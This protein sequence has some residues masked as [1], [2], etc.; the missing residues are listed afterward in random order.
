MSDHAWVLEN[1]ASYVAGGL[2][3]EERDQIEEHAAECAGCARAVAEAR[4]VQRRLATLF[5]E[6]RPHPALEDWSIQAL[7]KETQLPG[8]R[9]FPPWAKGLLAAAAAVVLTVVGAYA[10]TLIDEDQ[11]G[12]QR[13]LVQYK[14]GSSREPDWSA[15]GIIDDSKQSQYLFLPGQ[16]RR[17][18]H[19]MASALRKE[20]ETKLKDRQKEANDPLTIT[21]IDPAAIKLDAE[22]AYNVE[23][24][25]D[26]SVPGV[27]NPDETVARQQQIPPA[28][29]EE[30]EGGWRYRDKGNNGD[31]R[32]GYFQPSVAFTNCCSAA[33]VTATGKDVVGGG[34]KKA[35]PR[36]EQAGDK[37]GDNE[38]L[39]GKPGDGQQP[40]K[41]EPPA[42]VARKIIRSGEL[43]FEVDSFNAAAAVISR[44]VLA[45]KGGFV[46]SERSTK[47]PNG[48]MRGV[49]IVRLPPEQLD[50]IVLDL[51][52]ELSKTGELRGQRIGSEDVSKV[53]TDLDSELR[54][55][56]T[57]E[58]RLLKIIRDGKGQIKEL[59]QAE[60][61]LGEWR[62]KIERL[63]GELR[64]LANQVSLSTLTVKLAE[65]DIRTAAAVA[66][67][68]RVQT[69]IEVED[70]E[71]ARAAALKAVE[72]AKGRVTKSEL[73]QHAAGQFSAALHFEVEPES[74]GTVRDR[75]RQLGTMVRLEI[76]RVQYAE[77][78]GPAPKDG[79]V[80]RGRT[81]FF[82]SLYNLAN[83]SPR[84]TVTLT[85]AAADVA[86]AFRTLREALAKARGR[87]VNAQLNEK[88]RKNVTAQLDFD[89]LRPEEGAVT[90][91]LTG[92][93]EVVSRH[94][95]RLPEG[96]NVTDAK[97]LFKVGLVQA[98][99][100]PARETVK[101]KVAAADVPAGE[102]RLREALTKARGRLVSRQL[103]EQDRKNVTALLDFDV[104]RS[105]ESVVQAALKELGEVLSRHV[106]RQPE[107]EAV[108]DAK[109]LYKVE[110][111]QA[112]VQ[113]ARET[114][115]LAVEVADV[116]AALAV[117]DARVKEAG[118]R[119]EQPT[120]TQEPNGQV[121]ATVTVK[122]P[123][124]A[125]TGLVEKLKA[126]GQVRVWRQARNPK[127]PEGKLAH[128]R[129]DVTLSN[130][131][132]LVPRDEG[133][134]SQVRS[135][136]SLS[137]HGLL[138]SARWLVVGVLFVL[139]WLLLVAAVVWL[140]RRLWRGG[141][142]PA[143]AASAAGT[144]PG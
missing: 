38:R 141:A 30:K 54:A 21:D 130:T 74:A 139:P 45:T 91:A 33:V 115:T 68:E 97:L 62:T 26:V 133:L 125:A 79:K 124:A 81:Q 53:Y 20:A 19:E 80:H 47:L 143:P 126:L 16:G 72:E 110:L 127:A 67:S 120:T 4:A 66:E 48:K 138:V 114:V 96:E 8:T 6:A 144:G 2:D 107:G 142:T 87:V 118:G 41:G 39:G 57:M 86:A 37:D 95:A 131:A 56:R 119:A 89:I 1:A 55:A 134:G 24:K 93:G 103:N 28:K 58:E 113:P 65:K 13:R 102:A 49:I 128:V 44:L 122:A 7:R 32:K 23:R 88:D 61:T 3:D 101:L 121:V 43:E 25:A 64:W 75:L 17:S 60:Q 11:A 10:S 18:A 99:A 117:L 111:V 76:D 78:G 106:A 27:V 71:K 85:V 94:V 129:L 35:T 70:V 109:V 40:P 140:A 59:L 90:L 14:T 15:D 42:P 100:I 136:L 82:V 51:R 50:R 92:A 9:R 63:E 12:P 36:E 83:V 108:S 116:E 135:G 112:D 31:A 84:E 123:L 34:E 69:G 52:Q 73:K 22:I 137:L 105:E 29:V 98:D 77:G 132:L 104:R 46:A 5:T